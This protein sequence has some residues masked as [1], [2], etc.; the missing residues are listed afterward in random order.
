MNNITDDD[1]YLQLKM[2]YIKFMEQVDLIRR[3]SKESAVIHALLV[4]NDYLT[5]EQL[6]NLTGFSRK[7]IS[8]T[9]TDLTDITNSYH[10]LKTKKKGARDKY[11][12]YYYKIPYSFEQYIK[13]IFLAVI[14]AP[15]MDFQFIPPLIQRLDALSPQSEEVLHTKRYLTFTY[16]LTEYFRNFLNHVSGEILDNFFNES[17]INIASLQNYGDNRSLQ[18]IK[19]SIYAQKIDL[20]ENDSLKTIK[21]HFIHRIQEEASSIGAKREITG[22]LFLLYLETEPISQEYMKEMT[23]YRSKSTISEALTFLKKIKRVKEIKKLGDRTKY[24]TATVNP[25]EATFTKLTRVEQHISR[26]KT[27]V[28]DRFLLDLDN[29]KGKEEE[30]RRLKLYFEENVQSLGHLRDFIQEMNM[31]FSKA[32]EEMLAAS[33]S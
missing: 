28:S 16:L 26:M 3:G 1:A 27:M 25:Y 12:K 33:I 10:I 14:K 31:F 13:A 2:D 8:E 22:I 30:K 21:T 6:E 23:G 29:I 7:V 17:D 32:R 19:N 24:Y 15:E 20:P 4:E 18:D 11:K 5:Q 9:L